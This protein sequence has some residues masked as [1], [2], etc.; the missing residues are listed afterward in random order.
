MGPLGLGEE[1]RDDGRF[2]NIDGGWSKNNML[3]GSEGVSRSIKTPIG[4]GG[5]AVLII[6][7]SGELSDLKVSLRFV[8]KGEIFKVEPS[9]PN[10]S[11]ASV[12]SVGSIS[13]TNGSSR[14]ILDISKSDKSVGGSSKSS[15]SL[16]FRVVAKVGTRTSSLSSPKTI[17]LRK[18]VGDEGVGDWVV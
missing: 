8:M 12:C 18:D 5:L 1:F 17:R 11:D 4:V 2:S 6:G 3:A 14:S 13:V 7:I 10:R 9:L 16:R 15:V